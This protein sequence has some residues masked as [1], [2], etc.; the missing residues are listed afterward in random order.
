LSVGSPQRLISVIIPTL[1]E[2]LGIEKT[3]KSIPRAALMKAGYDLEII[4]VD[5]Q[6]T[7]TT[8]DV[9]SK[10]GA[11]VI[12]E[13]RKGYGCACK[14]GFA[15]AKGEIIITLDADNTYPSESIPSYIQRL[16]DGNFDFISIN[17]FSCMEKG[18]MNVR[19]RIGNKLLTFVMKLLY[20]ID[21]KDSQSGMW[22]MKKSFISKIKLRSD[23]M[24]M[25]EEIKI[26]AFRNFKADE[27][28][29][30]YYARSGT[31][32]LNEFRDGWKNLTSLLCYRRK[33]ESAILPLSS[34]AKEKERNPL[35]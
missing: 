13:K 4:V 26:I 6:S 18:A 24:S 1:N 23:D 21:V 22:V 35:I 30:K 11:K 27:V 29:G 20:S 33:L 25:S 12:I 31:A 9:A 19:R 10:L 14:S 2:Q 28:D 15:V 17:R 8:R 7:D 34:S 3:I 5:G 32:K 16:S